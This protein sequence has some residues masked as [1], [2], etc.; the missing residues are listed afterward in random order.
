VVT[1]ATGVVRSR[2]RTFDHAP[3]PQAV[4]DPLLHETVGR[5]AATAWVAE[6]AVLTAADAIDAVMDAAARREP[7]D[8]LTL[9]RRLV[10][11]GPLPTNGYF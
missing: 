4:D 3:T 9:G 2:N 11:G 1:D 8:D 10:T 7:I 5:L 6:A